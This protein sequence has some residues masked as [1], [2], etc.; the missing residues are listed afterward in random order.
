MGFCD[1][2]SEYVINNQTMIDNFFINEYLPYANAEYVK[3]YV[4]GLYRC[5]NQP[6]ETNTLENFATCLGVSEEQ[7]K[8]AFLYWEEQG[9]VQVLNTSV[10]QVLYIPVRGANMAARKFKVDK[11]QEFN[12]QAQMLIKREITAN[13]YL[14]YYTLLSAY[15]IEQ[16][17][18]LMIIQYC[19]SLKGEKVGYPYI[20]TV[21]KNW[22]KDGLITANQVEQHIQTLSQNY[23]EISKIIKVMGSKRQPTLEEQNLFIKWTKDWDFDLETIIFV[24]QNLV[25]KQGTVSFSKIDNKLKTYY[26]IKAF[27]QNEIQ[28]FEQNK[29]QML[30]LAVE[31]NKTLGVY[32]ENLE[33]VVEKYIM[34][35]LSMGHNRESLLNL[36]TYCFKNNKKSLSDLD[37]TV[38]SLY[39]KGIV[40]NLALSQYIR[41]QQA[42]NTAI[43]QILQALGLERNVIKQDREFYKTWKYD[44]FIPDALI[45]LASKKSIGKTMP[46]QYMNK[47]LSV[48][49]GKGIKTVEEAEKTAVEFSQPAPAPK[50]ATGRSYSKEEFNAL[51]DNIDEIDL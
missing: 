19:I 16:A 38:N 39:K 17:A 46:F 12:L 45:E 44:W 28:D 4:Y 25:L 36:A 11:F 23:G 50:M 8:E 47:I 26:E 31:I 2:S 1:L 15:H 37:E 42:E 24:T 10:F 40:S 48:W 5:Y 43:K 13:E 9:L 3:I 21:A 33:I 32:Y 18:L 51:F 49:N 30:G 29:T 41:E 22:A 34:P 35:W 20:L 14:E 7:I 6:K 27:T